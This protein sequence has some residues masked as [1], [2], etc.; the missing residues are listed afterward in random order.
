MLIRRAPLYRNKTAE[1]LMTILRSF[2]TFSGDITSIVPDDYEAHTY[3]MWSAF[4]SQ[5]DRRYVLFMLLNASKPLQESE[6]LSLIFSDDVSI[7]DMWIFTHDTS[8][9][10]LD[11]IITI[12][13]KETLQ[14]HLVR[15][16]AAE[17]I[18]KALEN[19]ASNAS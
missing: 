17:A 5:A 3:S 12:L 15:L 18:D 19:G 9:Y 16:E 10:N 11:D 1:D 4:T 2:G 7:E 14:D 8:K 6:R 13:E